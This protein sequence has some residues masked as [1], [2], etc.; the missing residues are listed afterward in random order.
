MFF[1]NQMWLDGIYMVDTFYAKWTHFYDGRN[2]TAWDDIFQQYNLI[3]THARNESSGLYVHGWAETDSAPWADDEGR[4]PNVWGRAL[5]WF[6][7]SLVE[8]LQYFPQSHSGYEQLLGYYTSLAEALK[9]AR[10]PASG[11]WWQVMNEPYPGREG[12]FIEASGSAMFTWSLFKGMSLGYLDRDDFLETAK[13]A[14]LSLVENFASEAENGTL[15]F[16]GTVAECGL[17][18]ANVTFEVNI[19]S[20]RLS[21]LIVELQQD[22][23]LP[24]LTYFS[25]TSA[26]QSSRMAKTVRGPLCWPLMNGKHGRRMHEYF[27]CVWWVS[28]WTPE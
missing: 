13:S 21:P 10:D 12:N 7:M 22:R 26:S 27:I 8:V 20:K 23:R 28:C 19:T 16:N 3:A 9:S 1:P 17:V 15:I 5:G 6:F 24:T 2:Q 4:A 11:N 18:D 14:Y 25:I